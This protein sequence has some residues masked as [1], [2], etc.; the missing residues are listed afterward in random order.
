M[1]DANIKT[2]VKVT[3]H[4]GGDCIQLAVCRSSDSSCSVVMNVVVICGVS[5]SAICKGCAAL[6]VARQ[7]TALSV[8]RPLRG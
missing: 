5:G 2:D 3:G 6:S 1:C 4:K 8:A 7:G